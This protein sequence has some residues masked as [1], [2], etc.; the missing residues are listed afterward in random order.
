MAR[1]VEIFSEIEK[2]P[3]QAQEAKKHEILVRKKFDFASNSFAFYIEIVNKSPITNAGNVDYLVLV[4][5]FAK[6]R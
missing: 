2:L 5:Q 3:K 4:N 6:M 1:V